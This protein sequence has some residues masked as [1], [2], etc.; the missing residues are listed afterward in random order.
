MRA[1]WRLGHAVLEVYERNDSGFLFHLDPLCFVKPVRG[2]FV[3]DTEGST[4][5]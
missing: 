2:D 4:W 3:R 1:I 5:I